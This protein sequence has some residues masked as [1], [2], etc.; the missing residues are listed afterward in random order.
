MRY[1][2]KKMKPTQWTSDCF[3]IVNGNTVFRQCN[4]YIDEY[5]AYSSEIMGN[6]EEVE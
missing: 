6:W 1:G 2:R 4:G 3:V 5:V